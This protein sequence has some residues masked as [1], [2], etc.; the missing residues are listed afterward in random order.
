MLLLEH[1]LFFFLLLK[2][3]KKKKKNREVVVT[4]ST[5]LYTSADDRYFFLFLPKNRLRYFMQI[6]LGSKFFPFSANSFSEG[7][8]R[9]QTGSYKSVLPR[10]NW[11]KNCQVYQVHLKCPITRGK[12]GKSLKRVEVFLAWLGLPSLRP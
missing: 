11:Q 7:V 8:S 5:N 9:N 2:K 10:Q 4:L 3:K 1:A 12:Y 6:V